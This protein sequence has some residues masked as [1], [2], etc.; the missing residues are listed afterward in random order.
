MANQHAQLL[1]AAAKTTRGLKAL[2]NKMGSNAHPRGAVYAAY[3]RARRELRGNTQDRRI[4]GEVVANLRRE[5]QAAVNEST[6]AAVELGAEQARKN[7]GIFGVAA[8]P[9]LAETTAANTQITAVFN[10]QAAQLLSMQFS[11]AQLLGDSGRVGLLTPSPITRAS[12]D[13][14]TRLAVITFSGSI[15]QPVLSLPPGDVINGEIPIETGFVKQLIAAVDERTTQTCLLAQGQVQKIG[16]DFILVGTPR[17]ADRM[18]NPPFHDWCRSVIAIVPAPMADDQLTRDMKEAARIE[19]ELR[20]AGKSNAPHPAN[21]LT[22]V[23]R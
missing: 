11:E 7:F 18:P 9:V 23:R 20:E 14:M 6:T 13:W 8:S 2:S 21:A 3:I 22:R 4:V 5:V 1:T 15:A 17:Y 10:A 19:F 12:V 16:D